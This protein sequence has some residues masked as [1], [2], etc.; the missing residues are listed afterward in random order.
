MTIAVSFAAFMVWG[1]APDSI[2]HA[3]GLT[4]YPSKEWAVLI[5]AWA[6]VACVAAVSIYEGLNIMGVPSLRK[7][8]QAPF[9]TA[10]VGVQPQLSRRCCDI[11]L[12]EVNRY[13]YH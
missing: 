6:L 4:Y 10:S 13:L 3:L 1:Y 7:S 2:L 8:S 9:A 12:S 11:P 5:P